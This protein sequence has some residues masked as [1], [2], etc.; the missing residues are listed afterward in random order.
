MLTVANFPVL[1]VSGW[2]LEGV[3]NGPTRAG[4][5]RAVASRMNA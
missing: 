2:V 4:G 3:K 5:D 1:L